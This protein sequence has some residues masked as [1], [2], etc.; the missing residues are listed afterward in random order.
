MK[1][2]Q[3]IQSNKTPEE[4]RNAGEELIKP[5]F[6]RFIVLFLFSLNG[7]NKTYQWIQIASTTKKL[8]Y[9]YDVDNFL[10]NTTSVIFALNFIL[11]SIPLCSFIK[12][13]GL[14]KAIILGSL[15]TAIGSI[16]KC[17]GL[18]DCLGITM[19]LA[20]QMIV[21]ISEQFVFSVPNRL[22]SVWYPDKEISLALSLCLMG[23]QMG[24]ALGFIIPE[25]IL[26]E[27]KSIE[28]IG[29][30]LNKML[31]GTAVISILSFVAE[32]II[33]DDAP[34]HPPGLAR[35]KQ[36]QVEEQNG[37][38]L[39]TQGS[40]NTFTTETSQ[41]ARAILELLKNR[42]IV[43]LNM[44][45]AL[46]FGLFCA[47]CPLIDQMIQPT[48]PDDSTLVGRTGFLVVFLGTV[49]LPIV[50]LLLDSGHKYLLANKLMALGASL[51]VIAFGYCIKYSYSKLTIYITASLIGIFQMGLMTAGFELAVELLY[52]KPELVTSTFMN[53]TPQIVTIPISYLGSYLIDTYGTISAS[54]FFFAL[55]FSSFALLFTIEESLKRQAASRNEN[56][57]RDDTCSGVR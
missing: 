10:I 56:K 20:G 36:I 29:E 50:G 26:D 4:S 27:A 3:T 34:Q 40:W 19:L 11:F 6:K 48:W 24:T 43:A 16:V 49:T 41:V 12:V 25:F 51:S 57:S 21:S 44:S 15:G 45:F 32:Y 42:H 14:R 47:L 2:K 8:A 17:F 55:Q 7:C 33:L 23:G 22:I 35:L 18:R 39:E 53:L 28:E 9:Y 37:D 46:S 31:I 52:P 30:G 1:L 5:T 38:Q 54:W 13:V